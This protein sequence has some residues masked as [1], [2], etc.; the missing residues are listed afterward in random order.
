MLLSMDVQQMISVDREFDVKEGKLTAKYFRY[1][2]HQ[3]YAGKYNVL[4]ASAAGEQQWKN[5]APGRYISRTKYCGITW[6]VEE[7][8]PTGPAPV[9][10]TNEYQEIIAKMFEGA[11]VEKFQADFPALK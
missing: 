6:K 8:E 11:A 7:T 10:L 3:D 2:I 9:D 4:L 5:M 1:Y